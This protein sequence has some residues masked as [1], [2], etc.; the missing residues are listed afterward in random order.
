MSL[1]HHDSHLVRDSE[2]ENAIRSWYSQYAQLS[3]DQ[4][5]VRVTLSKT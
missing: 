5:D 4:G 3:A 2:V 1:K